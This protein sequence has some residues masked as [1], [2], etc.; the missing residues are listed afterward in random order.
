MVGPLTSA[1]RSGQ[2]ARSPFGRLVGALAPIHVWISRPRIPLNEEYFEIYGMTT[3]VMTGALVAHICFIPIFFLIGS[4]FLALY[5]VVSVIAFIGALYLA[6]RAYFVSSLIFGTI[7]VVVH[8]WLVTLWLGLFTFV[9]LFIPLALEL[10]LL[11]TPVALRKRML[12]AVIIGATYI[13]LALVG[14]RVPPIIDLPPST[15]TGLA[16]LNVFVFLAIAT[17]MAAYYSWTVQVTRGARIKAEAALQVARDQAIAAQEE[18]E[19]ANRTKSTFLANM[20]HELRTPLNAII[21]YSE[22][23]ADDATDDETRGDAKKI[24]SSGR[25]LLSLI[26]EILDLSKIEAGKMEISLSHFSL[27]ECL[28][29][30]LDTVRPLAETGGNTLDV[31]LD[32]APRNMH[33]DVMK[34]RQILLNLLSNACKFTKA[35]T[36]SLHVT[37]ERIDGTDCVRMVVSDTGIGI[38]KDALDKIF[39]EFVQADASTSEKYGGTGLGLAL[40]KTL[41]EL[42]GGSIT[43]ASEKGK[44]S[45]FAVTLPID[46]PTNAPDTAPDED[47]G[48]HSTPPVATYSI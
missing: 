38:G 30:V 11:L 35:G 43:A 14:M 25:H 19:E 34:I 17:G 44:G 15:I 42:L 18:A 33:S 21:G 13:A 32:E 4:P 16:M 22:M 23:I 31:S 5:N 6:R 41:C 7:E 20:S 37:G 47:P 8:S 26:N 39:L 45:E 9:H 29:P 12:I 1:V 24:E 10:N 2:S 36:V 3:Y 48:V 27:D 46:V 40:S 28:A